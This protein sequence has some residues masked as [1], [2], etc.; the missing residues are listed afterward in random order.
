MPIIEYKYTCICGD[1]GIAEKFMKF[2]EISEES[3][4]RCNRC[5]L[6]QKG[7]RVWNT[8]PAIKFVGSG[9]YCNDYPKESKSQEKK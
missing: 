5:G 9:F 1:E 6:K 7:Q 3:E 8:S 2:S 4:I